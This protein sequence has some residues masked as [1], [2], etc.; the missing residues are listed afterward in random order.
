MEH[1]RV[2]IIS[3]RVK[4]ID[5]EMKFFWMRLL[6]I[7]ISVIFLRDPIKIQ[8]NLT[9]DQQHAKNRKNVPS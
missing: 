8:I 2:Q 3:F 5:V 4:L 6:A 7:C 9:F 1:Q